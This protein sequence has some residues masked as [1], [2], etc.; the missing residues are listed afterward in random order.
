MTMDRT[1]LLAGFDRELRRD[2]L[3]FDTRREAHRD[4]VT[5]TSL[6]GGT[7][8]VLYARLGPGV[9]ADRIRGEIDYFESIG[10]DFDWLSFEHDPGAPV[11]DWVLPR[12]GFRSGP[13][14]PV[15][16]RGVGDGW[17]PAPPEVETR[18]IADEESALVAVSLQERVRNRV[19]TDLGMLFREGVRLG[20]SALTAFLAFLEGKPVGSGWIRIGPQ[21]RFGVLAGGGVLPGHRGRGV[22]RALLDARVRE[23]A[24]RGAAHVVVSASL[25]NEETLRHC[26][27]RRLTALTRFRYRVPRPI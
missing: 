20:S 1:D 11:L 12:H 10:Q 16:I 6:I 7:G 21:A 18:K 9:F 22:Y 19:L 26:G 15:W 23:A 14:R 24:A 2:A 5:H 27:F 8:C 4:L 3:Y 17:I 13:P 25:R